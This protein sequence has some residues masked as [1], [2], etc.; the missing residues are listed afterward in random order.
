M[1]HPSTDP[2]PNP[3]PPRDFDGLV[4]F[5]EDRGIRLLTLLHVGGDGW[6]K[7]LDF[8]PRDREH[9]RDV[10]AGGERADGS[11]LF[12][13]LGIRAGASDIVLS[14]RPESAFLDP[15]SPVPTLAVLCGHRGRDGKPLPESPDTILRRAFDRLRRE[16]G[17]ELWA[18]GEVEY[19]LGKH[20]ADGDVYG[21]SEGGYHSTSPFV[22]G[23]A[24]RR[25]ALGILA[26]MGIGIKYGHSEVGYIEATTGDDR[27][28]EQ[29]EIELALAPLPRAADAIVLTQWVLRNLAHRAGLRVSFDPIV[30]VGH[31]GSG[32]HIHFSPVVDGEH[33]AR[34][35]NGDLTDAGKWLV[36]GL[37]TAGG[38]LMAFGNRVDGSFVRLKQGKE[39]PSVVTWGEF[40]RCALIRLPVTV[41]N[42][43]GRALTIP[44]VE[45]RLPDGAAHPP[46]LL[47]GVAQATTAAAAREAADVAALLERTKSSRSD[48]EPGLAEPAPRTFPEVAAACARVRPLLAAGDVFPPLLLDRITATGRV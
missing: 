3:L 1:A 9:L 43:S 41:R 5:V 11:S 45:F 28:W 18:L 7:A 33:A 46:L 23:E 48:R 16:A 22:F 29:H 24:L 39:A 10:L 6:L 25:Q 44:T 14:P 34:E 20:A 32:L 30:R 19:F 31:A 47:A 12:R 42:E 27:I 17:V 15:F 26:T 13:G 38:A 4:D 21:Q 35:E 40:D 36:A 8:V 37:V 2:L